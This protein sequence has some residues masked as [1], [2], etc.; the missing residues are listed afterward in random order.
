MLRGCL[1]ESMS[2]EEVSL[3]NSKDLNVDPGAQSF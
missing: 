2:V 3:C 1:L